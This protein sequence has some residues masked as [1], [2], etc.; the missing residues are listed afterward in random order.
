M[1][2][3]GVAGSELPNYEIAASGFVDPITWLN[4]PQA[5]GHFKYYMNT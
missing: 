5:D 1:L 4:M 3:W 2:N